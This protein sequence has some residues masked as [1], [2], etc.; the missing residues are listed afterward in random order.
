MMADKVFSPKDAEPAPM[1]VIFVGSVISP[2]FQFQ[3]SYI[4]WLD[5]TI[6]TLIEKDT[7]RCW[8][9]IFIISEL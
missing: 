9:R 5:L 8:L 4:N 1:T 2:V 3:V 6:E 7:E